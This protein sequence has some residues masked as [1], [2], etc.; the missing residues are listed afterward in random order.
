MG[1]AERVTADIITVG[2]EILIGQI[3]NTNSSWIASTLTEA[4]FDVKNIL[5]IGD[6]I[7]VIEDTVRR[8][9]SDRHLTVVTGGL[10][11]TH[12]DLTRDG[13][14]AAFDTTLEYSAD[15]F[16]GIEAMFTSRGRKVSPSNKV[17]AMVPVGFDTMENDL[18]TA[19]GLWHQ[20]LAGGER[21][22]IVVVPGVPREMK[23]LFRNQILPRLKETTPIQLA[24]YRTLS[25]TGI[26][27]SNLQDLI[28]PTLDTF[29]KD[30]SV[31]YLPNLDG[32]RI[33]LGLRGKS[34]TDSAHILDACEQRLREVAGRFIYSESNQK[35][36]EVVSALLLETGNSLA[37]AESCTGGLISSRLT[38][39][40]G[41]SSY[42]KGSVIAYANNIKTSALGVSED[43]LRD[44]GA[45]S[46]PVI[47]EMARNVRT[48][49]GSDIGLATSGIMGPGGGTDTKPV[50][51]VWFGFDSDNHSFGL[52]HVFGSD[53]L[54]N[55]RRSSTKA[56]DILRIELSKVT[57]L[58]K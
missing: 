35:I 5:T 12:D 41:A 21:H 55:K 54:G 18:G 50:G 19:P 25:L 53:R 3:V 36:E 52:K 7:D 10:G 17:Q 4:G 23:W 48:R 56:L 30:V 42:L 8:S 20:W 43:L 58:S 32:V 16:R 38:D 22:T 47:L 34:A 44:H 37:I 2:D 6:S 24:P 46:E 40:P 51:T 33:R 27:E 28:R 57:G 31:A 1:D 13:V 14:A 45:V 11:P 26:G 39:V 9:A 29:D 15:I 49:F